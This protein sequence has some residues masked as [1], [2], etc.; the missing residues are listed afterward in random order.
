MWLSWHVQLWLRESV[1]RCCT[2][3]STSLC[4]QRELRSGSLAI[5]RLLMQDFNPPQLSQKIIASSPISGELINLRIRFQAS[6]LE[7]S[8]AVG[9]NAQILL[10]FF[11]NLI[12]YRMGE[13][14]HHTIFLGTFQPVV[15]L[16]FMQSSA[17]QNLIN[18]GR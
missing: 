11:L 3:A 12:T 10:L 8:C 14:I 7:H 17:L 13:F 15:Q 18:C 2:H 6:D 1:M 4:S 16:R 5:T 9:G